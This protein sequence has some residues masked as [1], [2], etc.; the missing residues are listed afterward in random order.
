M[1]SNSG[2]P[3]S[4]GTPRTRV[5]LASNYLDNDSVF[6]NTPDRLTYDLPA[7]VR[8]MVESRS[9]DALRVRIANLDDIMARR[10]IPYQTENE[11]LY[12]IDE[13]AARGRLTPS[14]GRT[15]MISLSPDSSRRSR[16]TYSSRSRLS[17]RGSDAPFVVT[18][19]RRRREEEDLIAVISSMRR[20]NNGRRRSRRRRTVFVEGAPMNVDV[21]EYVESNEFLP[22]EE[23]PSDPVEAPPVPAAVM[24]QIDLLAR[25][26][27]EFNEE[28]AAA[29]RQLA[30]RYLTEH[31]VET[32]SNQVVED[33]A[34]YPSGDSTW[35][36]T[37]RDRYDP[38]NEDPQ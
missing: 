31:Q 18:P 13:L 29:I 22:V 4:F 32:L 21:P 25:H 5:S 12:M 3:R 35:E 37:D 36:R 11:R 27:E 23:I 2:T 34:L 38:Y 28:E 24:G 10:A 6:D 15:R 26:P 30:T 20:T 7:R 16:S 14:S 17:S 1:S 9:T 8:R 19:P 33:S